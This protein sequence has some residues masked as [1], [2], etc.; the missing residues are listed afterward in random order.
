MT[1]AA[2]TALARRVAVERLTGR[3][4]TA[5]D[6]AAALT[7]A[8]CPTSVKVRLRTRIACPKRE[9]KEMRPITARQRNR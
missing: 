8:R 2:A 7:P 3:P 9:S 4:R 1:G 5:A 6:A